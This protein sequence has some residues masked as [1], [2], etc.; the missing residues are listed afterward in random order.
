MLRLIERMKVKV[1]VLLTWKLSSAKRLE[2]LRLF[3]STEDD[4]A[5]QLR[6]AEERLDD[7]EVRADLFGQIL[8][9]RRHAELFA[10]LYNRMS[11]RPLVWAKYEREP[12]YERKED[13]DKFFVYCLIG[14]RAAVE[15]FVNIRDSL[16]EGPIKH[17]LNEILQDEAGHVHDAAESVESGKL[18]SAEV[19]KQIRIIVWTR[20]WEA[21][22]RMGRHVSSIVSA[23]ILSAVYYVIGAAFV[24]PIRRKMTAGAK[25]AKDS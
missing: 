25:T 17:T 4:S 8:E 1:L 2:S 24:L 21:W 11:P 6:Y 14:E 3:A 5:W 20:R 12:L 16:E 7:P 9:E 22:L 18:S 10:Q 23:I 13:M 15:R 19:K